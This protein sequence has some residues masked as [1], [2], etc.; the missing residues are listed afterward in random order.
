[1]EGDSSWR[2]VVSDEILCWS[3]V[4]KAGETCGRIVFSG[5]TPKFAVSFGGVTVGSR[6]LT[7]SMA[8]SVTLP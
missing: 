6:P 5:P 3:R 4:E 1:M 2:E 7:F 8:L